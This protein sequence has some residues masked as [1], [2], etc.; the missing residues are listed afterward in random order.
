MK[1]IATDIHPKLQENINTEE[2][3]N[4]VFLKTG[5]H[6]IENEAEEILSK[7]KDFIKKGSAISLY[8]YIYYYY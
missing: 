7:Y 4:A 3:K 8:Q 6:L 2:I 1:I 5:K